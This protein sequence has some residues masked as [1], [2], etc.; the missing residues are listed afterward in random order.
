MQYSLGIDA[1]GTFTDVVLVCDTD[2][3]I[4]Q[5]SKVLTTYPD[6]LGGISMAIDQMDAE[7]IK[8]VKLISVS[9]TLSTNTIL[10]DTGF[11][12]A[13]ILVG[14]YLIPK[15][16]F[17][18][19]HY[20]KISGGH[21]SNGEEASP[22]DEKKVEEFAH[23]VKDKISAFAV[24]AFFSNRNSDHELRVKNILT[25]IT[26]MPVVCGHE[27]S[28]EVGAYDR[29]I[30]AYL[31]AQLL[32]ITHNFI[33]S[34]LKDIK[35]RNIEATLLMLKCDGSVISMDEALERPIESIFSGPAASLVGASYLSK[36]NTCVMIDV[37][38]TSTD[39]A[40]IRDGVPE[41]SEQGAIVGGWKTMVKAIRMET[42]ATGG[43]SHVWIKDNKFFIGP[44]RVIPLCRAAEQYPGF[45]KKIQEV[46]NP[47][48][49][50]LNENIQPTK[51]YV[52]TGLKPISLTKAEEEI[53]DFILFNPVSYVQL[54]Q[55]MKKQPS[56]HAIDG[57]IQKRLIQPIGFTPTDLLH[58][59][60]E[61]NKWN[62]EAS[63]TGAE[64]ISKILRMDKNDFCVQV[65]QKVAQNIASSLIKYLV[66]DIPD[67]IID[68]ILNGENF[69]RF[70]LETP[71]ILL[72]APTGAFKQELEKLIDADFVSPEN[73]DVGNA[74][75][76]LVGK[77]IK[78]VEILIKK[79]FSPIT[80]KNVT[81]EELKNAKEVIE[82]FVFTP[83][84]RQKFTSH[85]DATL[86]A[87]DIGKKLV[88]D[89]MIATGYSTNDITI[90]VSREDMNISDSEMP[91]ETKI[92]VTGVGTSRLVMD[93]NFIP[94]YM[95]KKAFSFSKALDGSYSGK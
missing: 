45:L 54:F 78:R 15:E 7:L 50:L 77:G 81:D 3:V 73:A 28:Q 86:F 37:G 79:H 48:R 12:V 58:V 31:N 74:V 56:N 84:G 55:N 72:G 82:Y 38:G 44:R 95:R 47:S 30:T 24:S 41:L 26:G 1:G 63:I 51:F 88:M 19:D 39:V 18:T 91:M 33:Q 23:E 76:A 69:T 11:P 34:I 40:L 89:Y 14:D 9:T 60:G 75:G 65:K 70:K 25:K 93:K 52:R 90:K 68:R 87:N 20:I 21:T 43:D 22:L 59:L 92:I 8:D 27:L 10:E 62:I 83:D 80:G 32:P 16:G 17:P 13:A 66:K 42:S 61:L 29:A 94:D 85:S 71:I 35:N 64:K 6:P 67:I 5:K 57:L 36:Y 4:V 49:K 53:Y 2:G 46:K